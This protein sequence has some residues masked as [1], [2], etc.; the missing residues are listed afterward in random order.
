MF[1]HDLGDIE[2]FVEPHPQ[3]PSLVIVSATPVALELLRLAHG[4][5]YR[6][7]LVEPRTERVTPAHRA[8]A[9]QVVDSIEGLA[10]DERTDV[11]LTD[12]DAPGSPTR[13][14]RCCDRPSTSSA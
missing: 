9:D 12:H 5:G 6:T 10:L 14:R 8:E 1:H 3:P 4:L 2:V 7:V 11:V 13:S